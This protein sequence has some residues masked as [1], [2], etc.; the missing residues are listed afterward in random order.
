MNADQVV[1]AIAFAMACIETAAKEAGPAG[2]PNGVVFAA[3][4]A[5]GVSLNVYQQILSILVNAGRI[6]V[7]ANHL[8]RL[9]AKA[10]TP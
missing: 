5:H 10:A 1:A 2:A 4:Q 9:P 3:F 7:D 6:T 8:I